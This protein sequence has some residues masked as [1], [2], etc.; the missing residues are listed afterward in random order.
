MPEHSSMHV[1]LD[2]TKQRLD[3][4]DATLASLE[5]KAREVNAESRSKANQ[6]ITDLKK[7]RGEFQA[8][9]K[10]QGEAGEAALRESRAQLETQWQG[11]ETKV[12]SY[13]QTVGEELDRHQTTFRDVAAT[14][15][16]AWRETADKL[17]AEAARAAIARRADVEEAVKQMK[18]HA[19]EAQ[20]RLQKVQQAGGESW[21]ALSAALAESRNAFD[22]ATQQVWD[23]LSRAVSPKS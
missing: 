15:A 10:V 22:R 23:A 1:Y 3:E 19:G 13:F 2:W 12:R 18:V 6:F 5:V 21:T 9:A 7:Q 4:M 20:A 8:R 17:E 14:Q 16:K 11:F